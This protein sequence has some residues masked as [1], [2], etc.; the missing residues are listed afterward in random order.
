MW[1]GTRRRDSLRGRRTRHARVSALRPSPA[2]RRTQTPGWAG[3]RP[4]SLRVSRLRGDPGVG[5]FARLSVPSR[6]RVTAAA[7]SRRRP[8]SSVRAGPR[9]PARARTRGDAPRASVALPA[10]SSCFP[11]GRGGRRSGQ[12][13]RSHAGGTRVAPSP[14]S[15]E[16]RQRIPCCPAAMRGPGPTA[17]PLGA[18]D[19][20]RGGGTGRGCTSGRPPRRCTSH[21]P[22]AAQPRPPDGQ[23]FAARLLSGSPWQNAFTLGTKAAR[24]S[25]SPFRKGGVG[26]T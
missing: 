7:P 1:T 20:P 23:P 11:P 15:R 17:A 4:P 19:A 5:A 3:A 2:R 8:S 25:A 16:V 13:C 9:A 6:R 12:F 21:S 24:F 10:A 14:A 22:A 18:G 26:R